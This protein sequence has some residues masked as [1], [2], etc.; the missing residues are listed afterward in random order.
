ME[1]REEK[2]R[3]VI[4]RL[5]PWQVR[6]TARVVSALLVGSGWRRGGIPEAIFVIVIMVVIVRGI[7]RVKSCR[8]GVPGRGVKEGRA[9]WYAGGIVRG[10]KR[11]KIPNLRALVI[12]Q[13]ATIELECNKKRVRSTRSR[14]KPCDDKSSRSSQ[15]MKSRAVVGFWLCGEPCLHTLHV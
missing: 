8:S 5:W 4:G 1:E 12:R 9:E 7:R 11:C 10:S 6:G 2:E 3:W 13:V 14:P 15:G